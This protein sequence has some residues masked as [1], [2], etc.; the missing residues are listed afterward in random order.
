MGKRFKNHDQRSEVIST[1]ISG[2]API[3]T[4]YDCALLPLKAGTLWDA[5]CFF[6]QMLVNKVFDV[7]G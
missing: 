2:C 7:A 3:C 5:D 1:L 6:H 4:H